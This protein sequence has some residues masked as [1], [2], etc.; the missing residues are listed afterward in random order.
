MKNL[1][2]NLSRDQ[3]LVVLDKCLRETWP[4]WVCR[5]VVAMAQ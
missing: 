1:V 3:T 4:H 2:L 5:P